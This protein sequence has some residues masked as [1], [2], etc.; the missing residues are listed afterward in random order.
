MRPFS[1]T[2]R[3][4]N[5]LKL[6][7][8]D[9]N[10]KMNHQRS[11]L[12]IK[13][14]DFP[15]DILK[16]EI[17]N[18]IKL[19]DEL[20]V[21]DE[22][23]DNFNENILKVNVLERNDI[24][25]KEKT[26]LKKL[27]NCLINLKKEI[28][29][30]E[31]N[32]N[33]LHKYNTI[34]ENYIIEGNTI[35]INSNEFQDISNIII[36]LRYN[37]I[38]IVNQIFNI[39]KIIFSHKKKWNLKKIKEKFLYDSKYLNKMKED[40][41]F[42]KNSI[43][44]KFIEMNNSEIDAF[45][46]NFVPGTGIINNKL[47]IPL[48]EE[49]MKA[50]NDAR[51]LLLQESVLINNL[52]M[53]KKN[54]DELYLNTESD[55]KT[56]QLNYKNQ[57]QNNIKFFSPKIQKTLK[58]LKN[59]Y[60][61]NLNFNISRELYH[62]KK[63]LGTKN[64]NEL[65]YKNNPIYRSINTKRKKL[66]IRDNPDNKYSLFNNKK[67]SSRILIGR[68]EILL[69]PNAL[70]EEINKTKILN[71]EIFQLKK[72][73]NEYIIKYNE[74]KILYDKLNNKIKNEVEKRIN[75]EKDVD[76]L[77][78][79]IKQLTEKNDELL[80]KIKNSKNEN[81]NNNNYK[82]NE[83][84]ESEKKLKGEEDINKISKEEIKNLLKIIENKNKE[85]LILKNEIENLKSKK[86][87]DN[88]KIEFYKGNITNLVNLINEKIH[89]QNL[90]DFLKK[91]FLLDESIY[92]AEYYFKGIFPK[93][94]ICKNILGDNL[95]GICSLSYENSENL[96]ENLNLKIN[97]IFSTQNVENNII[98][99]INYIKENMNFDQLVV[100]LLYEKKGNRF[101]PNQEAKEIFQKKLGFK[102]LC[103]VRNEE[104]NQRYIKLYYNKDEKK[105]K[106]NK[107]IVKNNFHLEN[108]TL[109]TMNN[110]EN[111]NSLK[112]KIKEESKKVIETN[113]NKYINKNAIYSLLIENPNLKID[114]LNENIKN[115]L[116][117][118]KEKFW[119]FNMN[120]YN[121]ISLGEKE[122]K[123]LKN[124]NT[125]NSLF[126]EVENYYN[127]NNIE[128]LSDVQKRNISINF[129][130]NYSILI[131]D[132]YY[133]RI[134][135]DKIKILKET[136][137]NST[138]FLI[139]SIDNT[140]FFY[141]SEINQQLKDL[142]IDNQKN[143]Y[144]QFLEFQ[145]STQKELYNFSVSS[146]RDIAYIPQNLKAEQKVIYI[147]TFI[148]KTHLYSYYLNKINNNMTINRKDS[149]EKLFINSVDE[150]INIEFKPD[151]NIKNSFSIVPFEDKIKSVIIKGSFIIGIFANDIMN[152]VK[153][154]L[155]QFL[156]VT[157]DNFLKN[158]NFKEFFI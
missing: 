152:N 120:I 142:L 121:W 88:Y 158:G 10:I 26:T 38:N 36:S 79:K 55:Y 60:S 107:N 56:N 33:S 69:N 17:K 126:K 63:K 14:E 147:P 41:K 58:Q 66:K 89:S 19:W 149:N 102:W 113:F 2:K 146:T 85:I 109:I 130:S 67:N 110:E 12:E 68:D 62:H 42:L 135:S 105:I 21:T 13:K 90:P 44:C 25:E 70:I 74:L 31:K 43:L 115:E 106:E 108:F 11:N 35:N 81:K 129:E 128:F 150:Y 30:R 93:I 45:L 140:V 78:I 75:A 76:I 65:F 61:G 9:R 27:N 28:I 119:K 122:R 83:K 7:I 98:L 47:N 8:N 29:S 39:N 127:N 96:N 104:R 49:L 156:Y 134:S 73:N 143:I 64:Y 155:L 117:E 118:M 87:D 5:H 34:I 24:I 18:L 53:N 99:M 6:E 145:S 112:N 137:T 16:G 20:G 94:I 54:I 72:E 124:I 3:N 97:C 86:H 4:N 52:E 100:Y 154:P 116:N 114:F 1:S 23:K 132:I 157:K 57:N 95:N 133:N 37:A 15:Q 136:K 48:T 144:E 148:I 84:K 91:V 153:L 139:P 22:Y 59:E 141:I 92:T 101:F 151:D 32:I 111:I 50:I 131:D 40:L 77:Q 46:T 103:V 82:S 51:Y 123:Y 80:K 125:E 71:K 138:F